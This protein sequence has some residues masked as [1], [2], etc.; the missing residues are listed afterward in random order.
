MRSQIN[1][2]NRVIGSPDGVHS[3][4]MGAGTTLIGVHH[5]SH[6][7]D[8]AALEIVK[9]KSY[10]NSYGAVNAQV[11]YDKSTFSEKLRNEAKDLNAQRY[12]GSSVNKKRTQYKQSH[13]QAFSGHGHNDASSGK[14]TIEYEQA[15]KVGRKHNQDYNHGQSASFNQTIYDS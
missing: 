6:D 3:S 10:N 7:D 2:I 5:L 14:K 11:Y 4:S 12:S 15:F 1:Q 8:Q 13:T 9:Q